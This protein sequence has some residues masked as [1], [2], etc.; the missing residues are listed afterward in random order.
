MTTAPCPFLASSSLWIQSAS[1]T[2][3]ATSEG[4]RVVPSGEGKASTSVEIAGRGAVPEWRLGRRRQ[5]HGDRADTGRR[6]YVTAWPTGAIRPTA[7]N[8]NPVA[9][10]TV[11]NLAVVPIGPL[12]LYIQLYNFQGQTHLIVD[13]LGYYR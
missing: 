10:Q 5:P 2:L 1:W 12:E 6:P 8:L 9:G 11:A 3:E 7:S 4:P 13:V